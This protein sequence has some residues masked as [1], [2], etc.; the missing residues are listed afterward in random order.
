[1]SETVQT[2]SQSIVAQSP[3]SVVHTI[4]D[5][6]GRRIAWKLPTFLEQVR[7]LRAIGPDQSTNQPYVE[8][9]T[10]A[11][12]V[13]SIDGV[14]EKRPTNEAQ[15]DAIL[16]SLGDEGIAAISGYMRRAKAEASAAADAATGGTAPDPLGASAA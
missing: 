8:I 9:V 16:G 1:M 3:T 14:P 11:C 7:L 15:I 6:R 4:T 2:P 5:S 13:L 10:V 12:S